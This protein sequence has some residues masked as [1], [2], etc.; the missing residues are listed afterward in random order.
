[1]TGSIDVAVVI[2]TRNGG[3]GLAGLLDAIEAQEGRFRPTVVA[4]DSG[5]DRR[6]ARPAD[7]PAAPGPD[8]GARSSSI[9]A[10]PAT[11]RCRR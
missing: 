9:T 11:A 8:R 1:M 3:A 6:H 7:E 4:I 2:P 10:K 5:F